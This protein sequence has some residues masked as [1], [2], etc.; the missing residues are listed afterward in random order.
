MEMNLSRRHLLRGALAASA[1]AATGSWA[2]LAMG[3]TA[4]PETPRLV[5]I[6]LRGGMDGLWAVP[7]TGDPDFAA[8]RGALAEYPGAPLALRGPFALHPGFEQLH[9][10]WGRG[11][12]VVVHAAGLPYR[13]RSHFDAQNV[14]EGGGERPY[15][16]PT[17][18]LGR[19]LA[20]GG[21]PG[22][23]LS[24]AVPLLMRGPKEIDTWAP[25]ALPDPSPDLIARLAKVYAN[26]PALSGA[27]MRAQGL[28]TDMPTASQMT[29]MASAS[30]GKNA[31]GTLPAMARKAAE[32]LRQ[33]KAP[34]IVMLEQGGW[35][36]HANL[37]AEKSVF[38]NNLHQL[39][40]SL[41]L[42]RDA[43]DAPDA[44]GLWKRT[45]VV[46]ATEFG[47]EVAINGTRGTDHGTGGAAFV[48][49][50]A[51][52]GGQ[53]LADWPGLAKQ[54]RY[55]GRDLKITTDLRAVFKSVL[56]DHLRIASAALDKDV[57]PGTAGMKL[58]PLVRA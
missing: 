9:A 55:E 11:E 15:Q 28:R 43:L 33:P 12:L 36:S 45:I 4:A 32:F 37:A 20:A 6:I 24:T 53:V 56:A 54:D 48:V 31:V 14:L 46:V 52:R 8:A 7:A 57:F 19:A 47:R 18:W 35:D 25:S 1:A 10:M 27:L 30:T 38:L 39:D 23:A 50:G 49:G 21:Q 40:E 44:Q 5:A 13:D 16:L 58:P 51:V 2:T 17:G 22:L 3:G 41:G 34:Q 42:L 29:D 26:D